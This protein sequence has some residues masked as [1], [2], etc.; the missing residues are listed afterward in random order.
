MVPALAYDISGPRFCSAALE[1]KTTIHS[2][3]PMDEWKQQVEAVL[4]GGLAQTASKPAHAAGEPALTPTNIAV[5]GWKGDGTALSSTA[6]ISSSSKQTMYLYDLMT[7][8]DTSQTF[9]Q[10]LNDFVRSPHSELHI[11]PTH[12]TVDSVSLDLSGDSFPAKQYE[13]LAKQ[14]GPQPSAEQPFAVQLVTPS[15]DGSHGAGSVSGSG[16]GAS[17]QTQPGSSGA[18]PSSDGSHGA[19]SVPA[20]GEAASIQIP[21]GS[22]GAQTSPDSSGAQS[23]TPGGG[24]GASIQTPPGSSGAQSSTDGSHGAGSVPAG[25][26]AASIQTPPGNSGAQTSPGSSGAQLFTDASQGTA[27]VPVGEGTSIQT[28]SGNSGAQP[29]TDG[30]HGTGSVPASGEGASIQTQPGS[31]GAQPS[32]DGSNGAGSVPAGGEGASS[33]TSPGNSGAQPSTDGSN[34]AGSVPAGGEGASSQTPPGNSGAQPSTDG[35]HGAGSVSS[36]A[37][38]SPGSSGAQTSPDSSGAQLLTDASQG[39]AS[40]P[41]GEGTSIQ[42]PSGNSGAQSFTDGSHGTGSV[43]ASGE[44]ASIQTQPGSS[45][46][47]PF[48]AR[49]VKPSTDGSLGLAPIA[50]PMAPVP[51]TEKTPFEYDV[52]LAVFSDPD[53]GPLTLSAFLADGK[54]LPSWLRFDPKK[55]SFSGTPPNQDQ[56]QIMLKATDPQGLSAVTS[57]TL[58]VSP[59]LVPAEGTSIY[60]PDGIHEAGSVPGSGDGTSIQNPLGNS[61]AQPSTDGSNGAGSVPAGGE[62]A[63]SQTSPDNSGA[64]PSTDGSNG[65][66]SVPAGGEGASSQTPPGQPST[67]GSNGAGSVPAGGEGAS[68]QTLPGNSGAQPSTDGSNGAG[69]VPAGGE[70]AS[71]Q[72]SP[73]NP[74]AQPS[75]DGSIG[76]GSVP[77]GGEGASSQTSPDN[78]GAQPSTDG[79]NGAGSVP[80]GGE[81]ASSQTP[82]GNSGA[83]PSTDGSHGAGLVSSG[84]QTSPGSSGAQTSPD[85]SG[86]QLF[87][88][89][90]QGTASVPVG[91]GTSIPTPSGNSGAQ[92]FTDGSHGTGSVPASGEGASIQTQPGSS[93]AQPFAA[94]LVKP[95]TDGSLGLAPIAMPMAP[96][97]ATEKTPFEYDV[98]LA[99]FSDP[100][101]GPLTLSAFLADGKP[102]PSWLRFDP[103][104]RSFSG[105]PPNQDQLQIMLKATDPQG[106]SAVTSFTLQVSPGLVPA[107]G[108]SMYSPD[109]IHDAG[110]VPGSGDGTS[111]QNP[112]GNSGAQPSTDGSNGAGSV[113]AG[114]E[115]ASSQTSPDNSGAQ[116]STD[117]SNGAGSVPAGGEGAS[118]QTPPGNSGAQP[119]TDG[120]NGAGSVPAGGEGASSQTLPGNSGAQPSTDGSNGAGSVPA[121]G[122]GASSQTPPGN[123]GAQP[124]TDG[125]HGAGLVSSGAQTSPGS[126]GAQTS[127]DS[128]GAQL[129]TDASQGTASV[130]VGEGTSIQTP[131]GNSGAQSFTDGSHGT[132]SVPASGEGASIQ[133]QPG[134]SGAQPF[135]ARLVKPSTDGSLGLAPIAM[136]M[137]PVPATEKTPFEYDV[138]LAVFSD[139]DGGPLTLSAFL[140][141]GKPLPSWLRFDPKKRSFSGTPPNQDQLQIMLKATDPQGLS[142]VTSFTL[143]VSPGLVPAEGT[144]IYSPDGIHEAGSVPDSGDGTSIQNPLGNSGAQPSTDGSH[145][146]G[147]VPAGGEGASSQT[148]PDNS[149]AQPST[150]GSNGAGSV[151]AGGEG[152]S[153]Q[154]P[155][156]NSGAQPSTDGSNGAGSVP[157]GGEGASSQTLPGN[158][159]AQP[160]TDGSNGAGSVPA[161]G[162][163]ASSQTP[164]GNSGAQ[165]STDGS[166]GAGSVPAGG[167]GASSQTSPGNP[168]AQPSTDGSIGAGSVPAGGEGASSETPPGN[169]GAQPSTDGSNGAGSVPAGGEGASSQTSPDNSGAQ[170]STDG[171]HG[172]GSVPGSGEAT[173]IQTQPGSSGAQPIAARLVKPFTDGFLGLA[174][175][176]MPMAPVPAT[177][178][179][180][181]EYDVP[182][183]VFSDPDGGP[184]TLSAFLA[185]GKPLPS[186]LSFDSKQWSFSGTPPKQDQLHIFVKAL[187]PQ[188]LS[189][190]T[191]FILQ[192]S[193]GAFHT[194][195]PLVHPGSSAT[196]TDPSETQLLTDGSHGMGSVPASGEGASIQT[197]PG[198]SGAQPFAA[199]L[200]KPST[201][202]FLGLAP[203]AMPMAPVPATVKTPFEYD[204][205]LAV[206]SDPDGGPLTL[207]AF[208]ADGKP[209]PSW[210]SFDSKQWSFSGTPPKQDQ[211][212]IFVKALDPQGLSAVTGFTLQISLG[213]FPAEGPLI[214]PGSAATQTNPSAAQLVTDGLHGAGSVLAS[215][216]GA[217][218]QT[219]PG[220]SGAQPSIDG[221]HEAGSVPAGGVG[222]SFQTQPGSSGV[223]PSTDG[224]RGAGSVPAGGEGASI[225]TQPGSSG[226]Q[227]STDGSHGAGSL[228]AGGEGASIQTQPGS[229]GAQPFAA[230][231]VKPSTDGSLGLAPIAMPMA[232]VPATVKTP[233]EYDVPLAVFSD[234][235]GGPLT[236]SAFLADG[237]PLPSWLSF[238]P[239]QW[240]FS[241]TPPKQDQLL[242]FIKA[243]DPQ[244]LSAVTSFTLQ[245][246]PGEVPAEGH[247]IHPGIPA[248]QTNPSAAQLV[249]DGLHGAGSVLASGDGASIQTQPGSSGAQPS[250][251]GSHEAGSV[252]AGGV[253]ASFQTQPG[254]SGVQPSTDGS[255]GAGSVPAGGEGASIQTQPGSSGAL[256][257]TDGS[258][259][260]GSLP[261]GGEGASIQTQ[262]GSSGAL[263]STDGSR[264]AGSVPAGGEGASIQTQP[265]SSGALPPT[266]GSRGA[267]SVP[268]GGEGASIQTQPGSSGVQ[269]STDGSIGAGSVPAGGEGASSETSPGI[270]GAQPSTDGLH[271][272]GL[273]PASGEAASI[274]TQPGSS[275]AQPIAARLVKPFTDGSL[276]L[277][278]IAMPM[279]PVPATEKTPFEYDVPLAVFSDPDGGPLT[280]SAFLADGKP[281]PSW[282]SFDPKQWSFSG[283]PP[284]QDQLLVFIK[285][286]DPQGL[287]AVTSFT[288]QV[289]P[290]EVPA[291]GPLI[292]PGSA[293]TQTNPSAAQLVTDGLHGAGSVLASGDGASIQTQPGSSG[294]Q[295]SIDGSHEAGSVPA[296]G[297]GASFQTQ[298]GSSGVQPSTDGSH[299]AGSVPAGGEGASIQTQPGSS[300]ALPSTGG[301]NG[302][303][304]VPAGGEGASSQTSPGNSGAQPSTDGSIGAGSVPAGGEGASSETSPGISGAQ[305]STDGLH[306]TGLVPASGEAASIQ[307]QPGSSGAQPI[308]ARLVK[309]FTDGSLGLAPIAMPM[310][311]VPA[312]E[313]T[314]FEYDVPLAV[315]SDPDGGPLTLSAFLADGKPLPSWLSFDPKQWS[316]SGTP[317]KQDQLLVFIKALDPQ[318]L[319]AVTSFTLQVSPGEVPAEGPLIHPGIPATQTN[320]SAAQLVTD[321]LHG[322]GS[323]LASGDGSSGAQPSIDGS[324]EAGLVPA[325]GDGASI[326][327][328]PGSS[329]VQSSTD[330]SHGAGSLPAGGEGASIQT[331]PGSSGAQPFAARLV[332]PSTD[333]SL[334]LAPI[335]MP[336][337]PV[338]A[339]VKTP[340]E[341][342]VPLAVF[343]DPDGGPLTLSAFLADGKPLP[344]WLSFDPKQWSFSGTPPKQDQLLVFIKALDPQGLSAVTSFTL[345]VSPGEVPAEG[346]LIHPGSPT[347]PS[348]QMQPFAAPVK[349]SGDSLHPSGPVAEGFSPDFDLDLKPDFHIHPGKP[350]KYRLPEASIAKFGGGPIRASLPDGSP[351]P[352]WLHFDPAFHSFSGTPPRSAHFQGTVLLKGVN[353]QAGP[354]AMEFFFGLISRKGQPP[355]SGVVSC[356]HYIQGI[357][358]ER[359]LQPLVGRCLDGIWTRKVFKYFYREP[360]RFPATIV[361]QPC[362]GLPFTRNQTT[363]GSCGG[364]FFLLT[365]KSRCLFRCAGHLQKARQISTW[366]SSRTSS[367]I[368]TSTRGS[369]LNTDFLR[370]RSRNSE[371]GRSEPRCQMDRLCRVGFTLTKPSIRFR[372]R[373]PDLRTSR[374]LCC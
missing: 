169:S 243:L 23:S 233:F 2:E 82:P 108:T 283:T 331:Q 303:G 306:G 78:S 245:V 349:P 159:G 311:P 341:Y 186:W 371:V 44:G 147:S 338:P 180:P 358:L 97:P 210:L 199:R 173:S 309:P 111:I 185:D 208:L 282:L 268:A 257:S 203:I 141:D 336:M 333:G 354:R 4:K 316:F 278:P 121:H 241:G 194:E 207:S 314:P 327:T 105:T 22:S 76:A 38:T 114:G 109:G 178:K 83:Q 200:V 136:P 16:E 213:E 267:G 25:G 7:S 228:P 32:T 343:S 211:L 214:H 238:D 148:S 352:S 220:S 143:Q 248:T 363:T 280:L 69:S 46:A 212:H 308:A 10:A 68:S 297:V 135:A 310:A 64:Q 104:K 198:S 329:G 256:P 66:G 197:Q 202:G 277:A 368:S 328:Q 99:V 133:T 279:A 359:V 315:F 53:G 137:A 158:S 344:S 265:G 232:P 312:T 271:G 301:S 270:S 319:S 235:D 3:Q 134:S 217:S 274:Q 20:G 192:V 24:E 120:S 94:R 289:S 106:L 123:S 110:S 209:L 92:S 291:E 117:G 67:D 11:K 71:S 156:G 31:S 51:A 47:Q 30:S 112:L 77:A 139:P 231:L 322:A 324:H 364:L 61:G 125:S 65:A 218:I 321:G 284:K 342:D 293:A 190:V 144:S 167:E 360:G 17:S 12:V 128:S 81:G 35:S 98:P 14:S 244:G 149:G 151:P 272:T 60:S 242:V 366:I 29:S 115:G 140:A 79:S 304:S 205:P 73:D 168:G 318:G 299:G 37:Q 355:I 215:G 224:S 348:V 176:A 357:A 367:R 131:S 313:K 43:P 191:S 6:T 240:S 188:G 334:G 118:S 132:G 330:G 340:F 74:G 122:E 153:S 52:P 21:P 261:A 88:D 298:P 75:T 263:P 127:L 63:S 246:S 41:V 34:G 89:A 292:H 255:H 345:Q 288:L 252:P 350:F 91:E 103:K 193:P 182:L 70:G 294:A 222:A 174:P 262:P 177:E 226:V 113:P 249:T 221:S 49:L 170:P 287:S 225:Q 253:G 183:A 165:P 179:T 163:G 129:L 260:A 124:S 8:E 302:A 332:K 145:G 216:D 33:Q 1:V 157:A 161:G 204:V 102:L 95:S 58:Q 107:E 339:T 142:A 219:Q 247:L 15:T 264:G 365:H 351:L 374:V 361:Y 57:F 300:G 286:L 93:G 96:V 373:R 325:G 150:D 80:A 347:I 48:A 39:T 166:N 335:A 206:F 251:D 26:E 317:P 19:G 155:P 234:P 171:L 275:G 59:G 236:L 18:Q 9:Q 370:R 56:L 152:A 337:A 195:G 326:Q 281:L 130:P 172:T 45:G 100:D 85:S 181:F 353:P 259:G 296:G 90:S 356:M 55:R 87:T 154:T 189:A 223:K 237:K 13:K 196:Q 254:S 116:P 290:G 250:I 160:S 36:G 372:A 276:G 175:I 62:G 307:T 266:D 164:P 273:V 346:P 101:G 230:R 239:K 27:S 72:T 285:A 28:P 54:P 187:D 40:V 201:D 369:R 84:A 5:S 126:S 119:S 323:V 86:A 138:P 305:P 258:R 229:S 162:E 184:V 42:T 320:P 362:F 269:P 50:M 227:P 146:A 295:P